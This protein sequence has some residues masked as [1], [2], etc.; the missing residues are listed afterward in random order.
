MSRLTRRKL[1]ISELI[2]IAQGQDHYCTLSAKFLD[3]SAKF[4]EVWVGP[5]TLVD[6]S[7]LQFDS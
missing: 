1:S 4:L 3:V 5:A 2:A 6:H 7:G